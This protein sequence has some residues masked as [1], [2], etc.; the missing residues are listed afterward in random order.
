MNEYLN[1]FE[2][3]YKMHYQGYDFYSDDNEFRCRFPDD[4][5]NS[6]F[7]HFT[8]LSERAYHLMHLYGVLD[9]YLEIMKIKYSNSARD[10]GVRACGGEYFFKVEETIKDR[11]DEI[12]PYLGRK[13]NETLIQLSDFMVLFIKKGRGNTKRFVIMD[14]EKYVPGEEAIF[15]TIRSVGEIEEADFR[16]VSRLKQF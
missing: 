6:N 12:L 5:R 13:Y 9:R 14:G 4:Y 16:L 1:Y 7:F 15:Y 2:Q 11:M 3:Y 10:S 8:L